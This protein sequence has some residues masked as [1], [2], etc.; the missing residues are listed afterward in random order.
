MVVVRRAT[1][2][3][4]DAIGT[5]HVRSWQA[6]YRGHIADRALDALDPRERAGMWRSALER[7]DQDVW[8]AEDGDRVFGFL[9]LAPTRDGDDDPARVAEVRAV[10]LLHDHWRKGMGRELLE[11]AL[12]CARKRGFR[13][14]TLWVLEANDGARAFYAALGMRADGGR[15]RDELEGEALAE[16]RYRIRL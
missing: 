8:V 9:S 10:Y 14:L 4:A 1:P 6:V 15:K 7:G 12:A 13:E 3:D 5:V 16:V 2:A 11:C